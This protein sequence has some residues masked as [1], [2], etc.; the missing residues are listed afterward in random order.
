M[1]CVIHSH[2]WLPPVL[3]IRVSGFSKADFLCIPS[4]HQPWCQKT[5]AEIGGLKFQLS[6][7]QQA[8][9]QGPCT[10]GPEQ[11]FPGFSSNVHRRGSQLLNSWYQLSLC[12]PTLYLPGSLSDQLPEPKPLSEVHSWQDREMSKVTDDARMRIGAGV[13]RAHAE[14]SLTS[15]P[16]QGVLG[17]VRSPASKKKE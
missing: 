3:S 11:G 12:S 6:K 5:V 16:S 2:A 17:P 8:V 9:N 7:G 10:I 13:P 15:Q 4:H 14:A 1:Q